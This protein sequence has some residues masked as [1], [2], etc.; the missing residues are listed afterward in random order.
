MLEKFKHV[1]SQNHVLDFLSLG[2]YA[3]ANELRDYEW[4]VTS[5]NDSITG[6]TRGVAKKTIPFVFYCSE[7][8]ANEIKNK[9]YEH[10]EIDILKQE[11]GYFEINGYRYYCFL[12]KSKK[13]DY[14][15]SKRLLKLS[16]EVTTDR[17]FWIKETDYILYDSK[18]DSNIA[19]IESKTYTYAYPYVYR[20]EKG[21]SNIINESFIEADAV[22][23]MYGICTN[24][25]IKIGDNLYQVN[26]ILDANEYLEINTY[27]RTIYKI[28]NYGTKTNVFNFRNKDYNCFEKIPSGAVQVTWNGLFK[29]EIIIIDKRSEPLWL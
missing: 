19:I 10:F 5:E 18:T 1:N 25:F 24:P 14:F 11:K 29:V 22:I 13:S 27:N 9:F 21:M 23:R 4:S 17:P 15:K 28:S 3:N 7:E 20:K 26:I 12:T 2:I 8:K 6:L 16:V